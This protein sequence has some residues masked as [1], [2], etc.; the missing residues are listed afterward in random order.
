MYKTTYTHQKV[1][2]KILY[3]Y[4]IALAIACVLDPLEELMWPPPSIT[5]RKIFS[6]VRG[7][8]AGFALSASRVD[9]KGS[10]SSGK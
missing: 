8:F 1:L 9:R 4:Y 2:D 5:S 3:I 7:C 10:T 6:S